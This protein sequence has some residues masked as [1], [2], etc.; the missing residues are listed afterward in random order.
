MI[1]QGQ[2]LDYLK[3]VILLH[4]I[5]AFLGNGIY[6]KTASSLGEKQGTLV[7]GE[8]SSR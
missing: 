2:F 8:C 6:D 4:E 7:N 1:S 5:E 3:L